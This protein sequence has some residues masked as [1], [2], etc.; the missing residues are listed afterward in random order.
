MTGQFSRYT[1]LKSKTAMNFMRRLIANLGTRAFLPPAAAAVEIALVL[2]SLSALGQQ[3][4]T[5]RP[6]QGWTNVWVGNKQVVQY[7][8]EFREYGTNVYNIRFA[9]E[10]LASGGDRDWPYERER[11]PRAPCPLPGGHVIG[12]SRF[13]ADFSDGS[14]FEG[15]YGYQYRE[16]R[17]GL[18]LTLNAELDKATFLE[19]ERRRKSSGQQLR[20]FGFAVGFTNWNSNRIPIYDVGRL[21][22]EAE[23]KRRMVEN[24]RAAREQIEKAKEDEQASV[25]SR[26]VEFLKT[27][28]RDG[29]EWAC[30][31]LG[32]RYLSG[33]GVDKDIEEAK[34][35][36][37]RAAD[38][39]HQAAR[40]ELERLERVE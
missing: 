31:E 17:G 8:D 24:A 9:R 25:E 1:K 26:T 38:R 14:I 16:Y 39:G 15:W 2:A 40:A 18:L 30:C 36:F 20:C 34:R 13:V 33:K 6:G 32:K 5:F 37:K 27:R 10:W 35:L 21:M 7:P 11:R 3:T 4:G 19:M 23:G 22:P 29:S 12:F 28:A